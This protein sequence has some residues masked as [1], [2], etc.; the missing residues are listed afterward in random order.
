MS[1]VNRW[2]HTEQFRSVE[3]KLLMTN[4]LEDKAEILERIAAAKEAC[5]EL[6]SDEKLE[7]T[8]EILERIAAAKAVW[9]DLP[10]DAE[11]DAVV[12]KLER[13]A[14]LKK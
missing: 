10:S 5:D 12:A 11:L 7:E 8:A 4:V 2:R 9:D 14:E 13:I 3:G 6:P 1:P